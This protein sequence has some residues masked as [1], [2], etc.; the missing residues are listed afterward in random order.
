MSKSQ[1]ENPNKKVP[2][3]IQRQTTHYQGPIPPSTELQRYKEISDDLPSRIITMAE[4]EQELRFLQVSNHHKIKNR[5]QL[6]GFFIVL[7]L[8]AVIIYCVWS[9]A[10]DLAKNIATYTLI[11]LASIFVLSKIPIFA[12]EEKK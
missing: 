5:G 9:Q 1:K 11:A 2:V 8:I 6:F 10:I 12:K 4:K 3:A 7:S